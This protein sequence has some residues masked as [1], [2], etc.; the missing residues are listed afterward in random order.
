MLPHL[1]FFSFKLHSKLFVYVPGQLV[2]WHQKHDR[3]ETTDSSFSKTA[4]LIL[5]IHLILHAL[6]CEI[7]FLYI[8][9]YTKDRDPIQCFIMFVFGCAFGLM[10]FT[11]AYW[12]TPRGNLLLRMINTFCQTNKILSRS[13][14]F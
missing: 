10:A 14:K 9:F 7:S 5:N 13:S 8:T 3:F 12:V 11:N 2:V 1:Q 6:L 4:S